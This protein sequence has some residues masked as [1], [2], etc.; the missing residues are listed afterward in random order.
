M[1][2]REVNQENI[3][4]ELRELVGKMREIA[5]VVGPLHTWWDLIFDVEDFLEGKP[6]MLENSGPEWLEVCRSLLKQE[7]KQ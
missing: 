2:E 6:T 5:T 7:G 4:Q 3:E 1:A